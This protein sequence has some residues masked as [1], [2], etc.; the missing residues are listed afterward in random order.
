MIDQ[1]VAHL[2]YLIWI[3]FQLPWMLETDAFAR[4][5]GL[6]KGQVVKVTY[7]GGDADSFETYRYV[8]WCFY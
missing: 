1:I 4:Y 8:K 3:V 5:K 2:S 6:E 7:S